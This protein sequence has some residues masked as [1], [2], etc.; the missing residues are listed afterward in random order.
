[1]Q[2]I[3]EGEAYIISGVNAEVC[4]QCGERMYSLWAMSRIEKV[5]KGEDKK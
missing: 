5:S 3:I 4:V 2:E 1:M